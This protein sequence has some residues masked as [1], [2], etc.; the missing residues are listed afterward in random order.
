LVAGLPGAAGGG[1]IEPRVRLG[2]D[3]RPV[4]LYRFRALPGT[5]G[6][7]LERVG[8]RELPVLLAILSGR[9]SFV[10]PRALPP[11][12]ESGHTGPRRL[13]APGLIGPAQR[14]EEDDF[15]ALR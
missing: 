9:L 3:G 5:F 13:M 2:R 1:W 14:G 6:G 7:A 15:T 10:G 4:R 8:A 11:G 12:T